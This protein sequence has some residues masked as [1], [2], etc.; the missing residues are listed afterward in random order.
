MCGVQTPKLRYVIL[1][2]I[3][4]QISELKNPFLRW[5]IIIITHPTSDIVK[6]FFCILLKD[7]CPILIP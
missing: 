2:Q 3:K 1:T 6:S 7:E 5:I 4:N